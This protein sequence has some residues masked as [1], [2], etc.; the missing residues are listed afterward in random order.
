MISEKNQIKTTMK[1][2]MVTHAYNLNYSG[3]KCRRRAFETS[4]DKVRETLYQKQNTNKRARA[5]LK[6]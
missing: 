1:P 2:G 4:L 3:G 6:W 5:W